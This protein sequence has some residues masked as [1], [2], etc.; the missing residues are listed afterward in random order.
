M[1]VDSGGG[2]YGCSLNVLVVVVA[3]RY[4]DFLI[5]LNLYSTCISSF[6]QQH[7]YFFVHF[8]NVFVIV[9]VIFVQY[10]KHCSKNI[11]DCSKFEITW[12]WQYNFI[13]KNMR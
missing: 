7:P 2:I 4:I 9:Y 10:S 8:K 12:T 5:L 1:G 13:D 6:L 11:Q 3:R